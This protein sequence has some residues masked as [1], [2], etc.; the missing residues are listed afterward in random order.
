MGPHP[1]ESPHAIPRPSVVQRWETLTFVHWRFD[2]EVVQSILPD[3]LEV[4]TFDNV[5]WV[6]LVPFRMVNVRPPWI[7]T[8]HPL[9]TFPETNIRT[10]VRGSR[11]PGVWFSS[12]DIT[13]LVGVAV[14]RYG[15]GV[16]YVWS[17]MDIVGAGDRTTYRSRRRWPGPRGASSFVTVED[18][19]EPVVQGP[20]ERF[21]TA[22]WATYTKLGRGLGWVPVNHEPWALRTARIVTL[23]QD[24]TVAAGLGIPNGQPIAHVAEPVHARIG[25]PRRA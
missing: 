17:A 14:G 7:P 10:Y 15:F 19:G 16:P 18:L 3:G 9:T 12:L 1:S 8:L 5:A 20:L 6:G 2:P 25:W 13:R 23:D 4:D 22:R 21:L 11:G 24:L